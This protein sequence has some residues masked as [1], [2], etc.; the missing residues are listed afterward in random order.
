MNE[1]QSLI[2]LMSMFVPLFTGITMLIIWRFDVSQRFVRDFALSNISVAMF[3]VGY[4]VY[5]QKD[6]PF[7]MLGYDLALI[8]LTFNLVFLVT[9]MNDL[10]RFNMKRHH[11]VA[12]AAAIIVVISISPV[13]YS[14]FIKAL[15]ALVVQ[16][17]LGVGSTIWLWNKS[18]NER[19]IGPLLVLLGLSQLI[20][21]VG[22]TSY[23]YVQAIETSVIRVIIGFLFL[24][25]AL[26]RSKQEIRKAFDRFK[27]MTER[28]PQ[29][30][31]VYKYPHILYS[32][33]T[34]HKIYGRSGTHELDAVYQHPLSADGRDEL[35][36]Y[37]QQLQ[38]GQIDNA[39]WTEN[40][41]RSDGKVL[42]LT[43]TAWRID[44]DE[45]PAVQILIT[46]ETEL[47]ESA[48]ALQHQENHDELTGLPNR[49]VLVR[50]LNKYCYTDEHHSS[51][52]LTILNINRFKLFNQGKGHIIGDRVLLGFAE[53]LK[54][55]VGPGT[56]VMRLGGD[57]FGLVSSDVD[58]VEALNG[59]LKELCREPIQISDGDF[60]INVAMGQATYPVDAFNAD[61]L[62]RAAN[63][64][65]HQ[66]KKI[67][68][69]SLVM[70][71][72][73]FEE[74]FSRAME[75]EQALKNAILNEEICLY[76]QPKVDAV[77]HQLVGFEALAR[78]F[79]PG[80][81]FVSPIEFIAVAEKTALIAE[82]GTML[83]S[84]ACRQ[85]VAWTDE[86]GTCVPVAVNVSPIQLLNPNF[87]Q[88]ISGMIEQYQIPPG[89]LTL[90]ITESAAINDLEQTLIQ[91]HQLQKIGI[92]IAM[93][94]FGTGYSS[95]SMLRQLALPILKIDRGLID[96]LP[97]A[98]ALAVV[99]SICQLA[100]ALNMTVVAEGVE[101]A[102]QAQSA[103]QAGCHELQGYLFSKPMQQQDAGLWLQR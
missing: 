1:T 19:F 11:I 88:L 97:S 82:L 40:P 2:Y 32:N 84:V 20:V 31:L 44:W 3:V 47:I 45:Q 8:F 64:A 33:Q 85:I 14:A 28:S 21:I 23:V 93:D 25:S 56:E 17:T 100:Q 76:Y 92:E 65:M 68:G 81:G 83:L 35:Q 98:D 95:L 49:R 55:S 50:Q 99:T 12:L 54:S 41:L 29:G 89:M 48:M 24:F 26:H 58:D 75:Q 43:F 74:S 70:A 91:I 10:A 79:R 101:T 9:S 5:L 51:C 66:A 6:L 4:L 53:K 59:R 72:T 15:V 69:T 52:M 78:W 16:L 63:A 77:T 30:V 18:G 73:R 34:A 96:P 86:F 36:Y 61:G 102:E 90:E 62:L 13:N 67:P 46:D 60:F 80:V 42:S 103:M 87:V 94:D 22:G 37:A 7:H 27:M 57:E 38:S 71:D 39:T